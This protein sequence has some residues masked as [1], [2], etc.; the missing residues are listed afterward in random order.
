M[1]PTFQP[2][3]A[4][5]QRLLLS[6]AAPY[7]GSG[8]VGTVVHGQALSSSVSILC[9][10]PESDPLTY[11]SGG[12]S[13]NP[14]G[15]FVYTPA[16]GVLGDVTIPFSVFDGTSSAN[17]NLTITVTNAVPNYPQNDGTYSTLHDRELMESVAG[18]DSL[19][20]V[21]YSGT[22]ISNGNGGWVYNGGWQDSDGDAVTFLKLTETSHGELNLDPSSGVFMY[23]PDAGY[24]GEDSFTY[25]LTDGIATSAGTAT[26]TLNVTNVYPAAQ[27]DSFYEIYGPVVQGNVSVNDNLTQ[28]PGGAGGWVDADGDAVTFIEEGPHLSGLS[29][30]AQ[31]GAFTYQKPTG[32]YAGTTKDF[33]Y[34][35]SDGVPLPSM[36]MNMPSVATVTM[37]IAFPFSAVDDDS[38]ENTDPETMNQYPEINYFVFKDDMLSIT[39]DQGVLKNDAASE[40][41][42]FLKA[43][44]QT[45]GLYGTFDIK[46]SGAFTYTPYSWVFTISLFTDMGLEDSCQYVVKDSA[47]KSGL[48]GTVKVDLAKVVLQYW[49][50]DGFEWLYMDAGETI[51]NIYVG[52]KFDARAVVQGQVNAKF[53]YSWEIGGDIFDRWDASAGDPTQKYAGAHS[54]VIPV[55]GADQTK[56]QLD[57]H[58]IDAGTHTVTVSVFIDGKAVDDSVDVEVNRPSYTYD[59]IISVHVEFVDNDFV[60][61]D[62]A[63][64]REGIEF[65]SSA[66]R[67]TT[68][69]VQVVASSVWNVTHV[70]GVKKTFDHGMA[71]DGTIVAKQTDSPYAHAWSNA[72]DIYRYDEFETT[73]MWKSSRKDS[74][75]VPL[76][77]IN[78]EWG[79]HAVRGADNVWSDTDIESEYSHKSDSLYTDTFPDWDSNILQFQ[80]PVL[81]NP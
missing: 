35:I 6:G 77:V 21:Y 60:L 48:P 38:Y 19:S 27:S 62:T 36:M 47:D 51:S 81:A 79:V 17:G 70:G 34:R 61:G 30:N 65:S 16:A 66:D 13:M 59:A 22:W 14:D 18:N 80:S 39:A 28:A 11:S 71:L 7:A 50:R 45:D 57:F 26:V 64:G 8:H 73:L 10:D 49:G 67:G 15:S 78:W 3:A 4:L 24:V 63:N 37:T 52:E 25:Q 56:S 32:Y 44:K 69:L 74:E 76:S 29:L 9:S 5:E 46:D 2:V 72:V 1:S 53:R 23:Q 12:V 43:V 55:S 68:Q 31:T 41:I 58:W 20:I 54:D 42:P 40:Y 33:K 75:W